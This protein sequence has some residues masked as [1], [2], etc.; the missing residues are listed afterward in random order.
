[1]H[2]IDK[3]YSKKDLAL[4]SQEI[5]QKSILNIGFHSSHHQRYQAMDVNIIRNLTIQES[6]WKSLFNS[7]F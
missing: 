1:M 7:K 5:S 4:I 3:V 2:V 6:N